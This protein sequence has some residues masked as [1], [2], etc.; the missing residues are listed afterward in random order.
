MNLFIK[1]GIGIAALSLVAFSMSACNAVKEAAEEGSDCATLA[2]AVK[3][4]EPDATTA[5]SDWEEKDFDALTKWMVEHKKDF[6]DKK[7]AD[8]VETWGTLGEGY[9]Y[10]TQNAKELN[11]KDHAK[12]EK[13]SGTIADTGKECKDAGFG[14]TDE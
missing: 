12:F 9:F 8:A 13:A 6:S 3:D 4:H 5:I 2:G 10:D 14:F 1:R 7:F 11:E